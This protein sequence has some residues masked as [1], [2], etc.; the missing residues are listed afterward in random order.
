MGKTDSRCIQNMHDGVM[1]E[2]YKL[3]L[4]QGGCIQTCGQENMLGMCISVATALPTHTMEARLLTTL[5]R[6]ERGF[7]YDIVV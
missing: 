6:R 2:D 1:K 3:H 4:L 7:D 5:S